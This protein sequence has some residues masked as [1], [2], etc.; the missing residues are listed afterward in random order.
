MTAGAAEPDAGRTVAVLRAPP[1]DG[2]G[3]DTTPDEAR[4]ILLADEADGPAP[5]AVAL[6]AALDLPGAGPVEGPT[7]VVGTFEVRRSPAR[8]QVKVLWNASPHDANATW[9]VSVLVARRWR[10]RHRAAD[11]ALAT[12][13]VSD[14]HR[15]LGTL[16]DVAD[17]RWL[18]E[19]EVAALDPADD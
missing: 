15:A 18:T 6:H 4:R 12:D 19:A 5:I 17:V 9:A 13:L 11:R 14:V 3:P 1:P 16:A 2:I 7:P 8:V 10:E